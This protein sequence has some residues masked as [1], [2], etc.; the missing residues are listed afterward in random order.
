MVMM[1]VATRDAFSAQEL[2]RRRGFGEITRGGI[3]SV[4]HADQCR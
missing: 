1:V 4:F 3:D 2:A